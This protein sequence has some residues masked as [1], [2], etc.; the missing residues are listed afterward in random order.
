[1]TTKRFFY[2]PSIFCSGQIQ[3]EKFI[4]IKILYRANIIYLVKFCFPVQHSCVPRHML[5]KLRY[6]RDMK[7]NICN[8]IRSISNEP[9][10]MQC[11]NFTISQDDRHWPN[12]GILMLVFFKI[13][14]QQIAATAVDLRSVAIWLSH[15]TI[16]LYIYCTQDITFLGCLE[17]RMVRWGGFQ[18]ITS[19]LPI[20]VSPNTKKFIWSWKWVYNLN[21]SQEKYCWW[22]YAILCL[23]DMEKCANLQTMFV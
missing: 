13:V 16:L 12:K 21:I 23:P 19:Q 20:C 11:N 8:Q 6:F 4:H 14:K 17:A 22:G 18:S 10:D 2:L 1:M 3:R 7:N 15:V 5:K 9:L